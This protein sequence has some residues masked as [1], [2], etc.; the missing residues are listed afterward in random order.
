M[1]SYVQRKVTGTPQ[2]MGSS[3]MA[4][5]LLCPSPFLAQCTHPPAAA[6]VA[7]KGSQLPLLPSPQD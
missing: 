7:A 4:A 3:V 6:G 5:V 2:G 1:I